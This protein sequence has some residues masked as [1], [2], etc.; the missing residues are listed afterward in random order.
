MPLPVPSMACRSH[1]S[2]S[3]FTRA[4]PRMNGASSPRSRVSDGNSS[5]SG[6]PR[7]K[8]RSGS[9]PATWPGLRRIGSPTYSARAT[10]PSGRCSALPV[11]RSPAYPSS[12][13]GGRMTRRIHGRRPRSSTPSTDLGHGRGVSRPLDGGRHRGAHPSARD[14]QDHNAR[15]GYLAPHGARGAS[16]RRDSLVLGTNG[17]PGLDL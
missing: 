17:L 7:F 15:V 5:R 6:P 8:W 3:P 1:P 14:R 9:S 11:R 12:S 16:R 4:G 13:P 2:S 10:R